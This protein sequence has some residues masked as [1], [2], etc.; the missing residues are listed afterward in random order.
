[1]KSLF[2]GVIAVCCALTL[3][4]C[5]SDHPSSLAAPSAVIAATA[6]RTAGGTSS[7]PSLIGTWGST[8][9]VTSAA[10][11][12]SLAVCSNI[13]MNITSQ[14]ATQ[15]SGILSMD[16]PENVSI[17]GTLVGQLGGPTIPLSWNG[18][19]TQAGFPSCSFSMTGTG[20][21]LGA[22]LFRLTYSGN[23]CR[24]A[25]EGSDTLRFAPAPAATPAPPASPPP[26]AARDGI[27]MSQAVIRNSPLNLASWPITTGI[28]VVEMRSNGVHL[29]FSK[30]NG[31]NRWPDVV[32][33]GWDGGLQWTLGMALNIGGRWY[34]SAPVQFWHGLEE[35][36]GPPQNYALNWFYDPVRW[37]PMTGHQPVV[38]E[39]IG[40]FACA[41]DCRNN[42]A[43]S[44][45]PVKERS[46]VVLVT[47]PGPGGARFTF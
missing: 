16:C 19:A 15:A 1:M 32:P 28:N 8:T 25:V 33:P 7:T 21:P 12:I 40:F 22:D 23:S 4:A 39:T 18:S 24:G 38:G 26:G 30:Q 27:D 11:T 20:I 9:R 13:Q 6:S 36:G 5:G 47:F 45:S 29:E 2:P 44:L 43:G 10:A 37:A 3:A 46:N 17:T 34:A 42:T 31:P 35:S 41:G 14:T